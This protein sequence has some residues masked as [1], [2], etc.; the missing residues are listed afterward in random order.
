M[1]ADPEQKEPND[2]ARVPNVAKL[3]PAGSARAHSATIPLR[4]APLLTVVIPTFNESANVPIII[5]RVAAALAEVD[6]EIIFVDDDFPDSDIDRRQRAGRDRRT[7]A[8]FGAWG[9]ADLPAPA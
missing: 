9:A 2:F 1:I 8:L 5:E 6:W 7:R 3:W 4:P